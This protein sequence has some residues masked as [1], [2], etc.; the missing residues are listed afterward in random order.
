MCIYVNNHDDLTKRSFS[1][2]DRVSMAMPFPTASYTIRTS[3]FPM[4]R[5]LNLLDTILPMNMDCSSVPALESLPLFTQSDNTWLSIIQGCASSLGSLT[6]YVVSLEFQNTT[7]DI[8]L[9]RLYFLD[10]GNQHEL[11]MSWLS[12]TA[13]TLQVYMDDDIL[14]SERCRIKNGLQLI[15]HLRLPEL[16]SL[17]SLSNLRALQTQSS[18]AVYCRLLEELSACIVS[19]P[20]LKDIQ[21]LRPRRPTRDE[22]EIFA[23]EVEEWNAQNGSAVTLAYVSGWREEPPWNPKFPVSMHTF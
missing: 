16:Q 5:H 22:R 7:V 8:Y 21:F 23:Q 20:Y 3:S 19:L 4:P 9:P 15:T 18:I 12:I 1:R 14:E 2:L 13:P 6:L 10:I 17:H 11:D